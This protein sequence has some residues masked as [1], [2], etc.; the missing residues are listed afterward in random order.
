MKYSTRFLQL[1][2]ILIFA[3]VSFAQKGAEVELNKP[4]QYENRKLASEK[5]GEKK[6]T[7]ARRF[8]QNTTTHYNYYFNA[9]N[10]LKEVVEKAKHDFKEDYSTLLPFYNYTLETTSKDKSELDSVVYKSTAG[11]LLHDLR[12]DWVDN[13]YLLLAKAYFFRKDLDSSMMTL[14]YLNFAF[15]PK[16]DGGYD[17]PIGSNSSNETGEFSV[18]T[19]EKNT[20]VKKMTGRPPSR[21]EGFIW[22]IRC[23]IENEELAEAAGLLEILKND[24][25]FPERLQPDLHEVIAH[26][27]Y[28]QEIYDS[29]AFHLS[30]ALS[31]ATNKQER[32]RWEYLIGQMYQQSGNNESAI[33]FFERSIAHTLD[34]VMEVYARLSALKI[35]RGDSKDYQ[36]ENID[37]LIKM[38]KRDK[39]INYRDII[40]YA[41]ASIELDRKEYKNAE[42]FL[43]KSV[44]S[45]TNN[46][47]QRSASF[48]LLAD[49]NYGIKKYTPASNYYDST[50]I[51]SLKTQEEKDRVLTRKPPL[52][53]VA[54]NEMAVYTEDSLQALAL[55]PADKR[56]E[57]L[58]KKA[59][60]LRKIQ[61]IKEEESSSSSNPDIPNN[62]P[63]DLFVDDNKSTDFYFYNPSQKARGFSEF[64]SRWGQ[65]PNV[66]NWRRL[67]AVNRKTIQPGDIDVVNTQTTEAKPVGESS[68]EGLLS[69]L[70]LTPEQVITSNKTIEK[71]LYTLGGTFLSAMEDYPSAITAY[72]ELLR[73]FPNTTYR[74]EALF[75]LVYAYQK[76]GDPEKSSAYKKQL[77]SGAD[78]SKWVKLIKNP[79]LSKREDQSSV[80]ATKKYE[81]IY[82][83][84]IEGQ[85][86]K[87]KLEKKTADDQYGKMYWTP[88]LVYIESIYY[89]KEKAD[90]TAIQLLTILKINFSDNP[91]AEK[92]QTMIDV[93]KRRSEIED[94]LT[95]LEVTRNEGAPAAKTIVAYTPPA[96]PQPKKPEI[97]DTVAVAKP[98][99]IA[100][101]KDTA[102]AV[103][104]AKLI[105]PAKDTVA[106]APVT[107]PITQ[108]AK[109]T[110]AKTPVVVTPAK[111]DTVSQP[112]TKTTVPKKDSVV[113][114]PAI[115]KAPE[116]PP[117][118]TKAPSNEPKKD[119]LKS[120]E[121][122][123]IKPKDTIP[124]VVSAPV[125]LPPVVEKAP[126]TAPV[127]N[128]K[129]FTFKPAD[130]HYVVVVLDKVDPVYASEAKNAFN[131][132]NR[133]KF[134]NKPIDINSLQLDDRFHLLLEGP[135]GDAN[136]AV[137]YVDNVR[138]Q[139]RSRILPW[140]TAEK[141]NFIVISAAN[142]EVLKNSKDMNSYR[143]LLNKAFPGKF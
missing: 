11:I 76:T 86:E 113:Q 115:V 101:A 94:Y 128:L 41:A 4:A 14:Q 110:L 29:S 136:A 134:Y 13:M 78:S 42:D 126:E 90:S 9:N 141:Y 143:E 95:K 52:K 119:T 122:V 125:T 53:I 96:I 97:K 108:P 112:V 135:F 47:Q 21:N 121:I 63:G 5:T 12:S 34:P 130:E 118:V 79:S 20:I 27:F 10:R 61:G 37:A 60:E 23:F 100:L 137:D 57:I 35:N 22:Q 132:F 124:A 138:P 116:V 107:K 77:S 38:A 8:I 75:N 71:S 3:Q 73:R 51:N 17:I 120:A 140:L 142:L 31:E 131:R 32:A 54:A 25:Q 56:D 81:E 7:L 104:I 129:G 58:K 28:K 89:I 83:L 30:K 72:E 18:V 127:I 114:A 102:A 103:A 15:A 67:S 74:D 64:K 66:D 49:M 85:F 43:Q 48:L 93:L 69:N 82:N 80:L 70:P 111:K 88:Q 99:V 133:E 6:F 44:Q 40:Y 87:A 45:N 98:P 19:K 68:Y 16:E 106:T 50:D 92:A 2:F 39:Y 1:L 91:M 59:K 84:F 62:Q 109:D 105:Q 36:Q 33:D 46:P 123:K 65:R 117:V 26:W 55:L 24:P 139:A